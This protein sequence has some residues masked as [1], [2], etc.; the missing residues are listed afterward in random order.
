[1]WKKVGVTGRGE[2]ENDQ[3]R[4]LGSK[5]RWPGQTN[6]QAMNVM[7]DMTRL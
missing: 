2:R 3:T 7:A 4:K 5:E 6:Y 1:M